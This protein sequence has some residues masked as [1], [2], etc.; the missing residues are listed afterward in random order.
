MCRLF[1]LV[2]NRQVDVNFSFAQAP[3]SLV[4]QSAWNPD[5]WGIAWYD[6]GRARVY[7]EP[8][9]AKE[10]EY[11]PSLTKEIKASLIIAHVR[12]G[13]AGGRRL[14][15]THPFQHGNFVF[16]HNGSIQTPSR[17]R[18]MLVPDLNSQIQG[19]TDS[20][21]YFY[22]LLQ[23]IQGRQDA[24]AGVRT[25]IQEIIEHHQYLGL[26]FLLCDGLSL[27][28]FRYGSGSQGYYSLFYLKRDPTSP[29][30]LHAVS[31]ET[32]QLIEYKLQEDEK[33]VLVV[34]EKLTTGESWQEIPWDSLTIVQ[35]NLAVKTTRIV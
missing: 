1:G 21:L 19:E 23:C 6:K 35:P 25:A 16:A 7:K 34:S 12:K 24:V 22:W 5:G 27:Y 30:Y 11:L 15:N 29:P 17:L 8:I 20:E 28:A 33:A 3:H 18:A 9:P 32:R 13:T 14:E 31:Q 10:S 4:S 2:A 26:N